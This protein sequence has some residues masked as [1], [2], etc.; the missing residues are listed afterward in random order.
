MTQPTGKVALYDGDGNLITTLELDANGEAQYSFQLDNE[1]VGRNKLRAVYTGDSDYAPLGEDTFVLEV[2]DENGEGGKKSKSTTVKKIIAGPGIYISPKD[3]RGDVTISTRPISDAGDEDFFRV[4]WTQTISNKFGTDLSFFLACGASGLLMSSDDGQS[5]S[6]MGPRNTLG[7]GGVSVGFDNIGVFQDQNFPGDGMVYYNIQDGTFSET[8]PFTKDFLTASYGVLGYTDA[9][10]VLKGDNIDKGNPHL[11]TIGSNTE[12][13]N[14]NVL[15]SETFLLGTN[16]LGLVFSVEGKI[17]SFGTFPV[18]LTKS[19]W[20]NDFNDILR[21]E[22]TGQGEVL[23]CWSNKDY[24]GTGSFQVKAVTSTGKIL[25]S[26]RSG[27]TAGTWS[28]DYNGSVPLSNI[29]YNADNNTWIAVGSNNTVLVNSQGGGWVSSPPVNGG[30]WYGVAY[31]NGKWVIVGQ[32]GAIG[33][34]LDNGSTWQLS[35]SGTKGALFDVA[36]SPTLNI[37]A[38]VGQKRYTVAITGY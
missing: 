12:I 20:N 21:E 4:R 35:S 33:V 38:A 19:E 17:W 25:N 11:T 27:T 32:N 28:V 9:N 30:T 37:F 34:S 13:T 14:Q 3:G 7:V 29:G 24:F 15:Y 26:N 5:W 8:P 23:G 31:G 16:Y 10:G 22:A 1:D 18:D 2:V 36:Y 6:D